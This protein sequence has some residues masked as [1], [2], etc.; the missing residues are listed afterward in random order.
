[1]TALASCGTGLAAPHPSPFIAWWTRQFRGG[2]DQVLEVRRW[3]EDLL[4]DCTARADVLLVASELCTNA[5]VHS[6]SGEAGGQFS[7]DIDWAPT[8]ARV[9]I[10]DQG[11]VKTPAIA[12]RTGDAG[13]LGESGRGLLLVDDVA[14]DWGTASRPNRRWVWADVA[15]HSRGG[16]PLAAPGGLDAAI[17]SN[18]M[19][20]KA[21]PGTSIW[22]GHLSE[23]WWAAVPGS[24]NTH[25]LICAPTRDSL[26][27]SLVRTYPRATGLTPFRAG[28]APATLARPAI[29]SSPRRDQ[30]G[31]GTT[32]ATA[33]PST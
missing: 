12:A 4:P 10:G 23:V 13:P 15:W 20:H 25:S 14:D 16:L 19:I 6:R 3:L 24:T 32:C 2:A 7:V 21:F 5:I 26:I 29:R 22:W 30:A 1:M 17:A 33:S 11:S 27:K 9:V 8:L 18:T 28:S 31:P